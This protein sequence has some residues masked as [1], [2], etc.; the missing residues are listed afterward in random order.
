MI[1]GDQQLFEDVLGIV[2][3]WVPSKAYDHESKFQNELQEF[4]DVELN[5]SEDQG[6][7]GIEL[8]PSRDYVVDREHGQSRAD[9]AVDDTVGIE[10]KRNLSNSKAKRELRGQIEGYL[11]NYPFVIVVACGLEDTSQ[12]RNLKNK[13]EG[14]QGIVGMDQGGTVAFVHKERDNYGKDPDDL[15]GG[16]GMFGDGL[17]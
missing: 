12:W 9:I 4:L 11:D 15:R 17:L 3:Y 16:G 7:M 14:N 13:Y 6:P 8:G 1:G 10:M 2:E 5:D